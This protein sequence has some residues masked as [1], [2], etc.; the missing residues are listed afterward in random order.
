MNTSNNRTLITKQPEP[1]TNHGEKHYLLGED[2]NEQEE[3][4]DVSMEI[5]ANDC[6]SQHLSFEPTCN[7][8]EFQVAPLRQSIGLKSSVVTTQVCASLKG[9]EL[10]WK[11]SRSPV[12]IVVALDVSGEH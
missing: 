5:L 3:A 6:C 1:E 8:I 2:D 9:R 4:A 11:D 12:D 10:S 7:V